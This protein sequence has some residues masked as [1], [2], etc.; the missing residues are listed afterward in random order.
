L[1]HCRSAEAVEAEACLRGIHL[2]LEWIRQPTCLES[3]CL[4]LMKALVSSHEQ[5]SEM[6]GILIEVRAAM[7]LLPQITIGHV[8]RE[9]NSVA[10]ELAQRTLKYQ[11]C[12]FMRHD[13]PV[14]VRTDRYR[15]S[16]GCGF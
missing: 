7:Q 13:V 11:E 8:R 10:H 1:R 9:A 14:F 16:R 3:D 4:A 15:G 5:H 2:V 12:V 6:A